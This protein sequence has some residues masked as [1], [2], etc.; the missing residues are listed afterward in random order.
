[1]DHYQLYSDTAPTT[2]PTFFPLPSLLFYDQREE[3]QT[4]DSTAS[5]LEATNTTDRKDTKY[6]PRKR[7]YT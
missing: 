3:G 4:P 5:R 7:I 6:A 2:S 1:L